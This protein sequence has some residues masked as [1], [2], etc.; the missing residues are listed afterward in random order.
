MRF[1]LLFVMSTMLGSAAKPDFTGEWRLLPGQ[2]NFVRQA[3]PR[4]NFVQIDHRDPTLVIQIYEEDARGKV[5]GT[6]FHSTDGV[7]RVNDV[8][9]NAMKSVTKW[10][11]SVLEMRTTGNFGSNE[12]MLLDRYEL[13]A[14]GRTLTVKRHFEGRSPQGEMPPQDQTLVHEL[15]TL[16]AGVAR[17]EITPSGSM[18]MYGYANRACGPS[19]GT[20][21]PLHAKVVVLESALSRIAIVTLDLGSMTSDR[22]RRDVAEKLHIPLVLLASSHTHS[23]PAFLPSLS[24]SQNNAEYLAELEKKIFEAIR[25]ASESMF[26]ARLSVGRG[27]V[28]LGYNRLVRRGHDRTR[29]VFDNLE[30]IP[31]GP[32]DPEFMLLEV[33]DAAGNPKALLVHYAVHAVVLGPKSCKFSADFPGAMQSA[34]EAAVPGIQAMF[35]QGGA[36]DINPLFQG[37]AGDATQ[38]FA[39]VDRMGN[40]LATEV[41]KARTS[42]QAMTQRSLPI[43]SSSA[44][45]TFSD[46]WEKSRTHEIGLSTVLIG[47][48]IAIAAIP[49]EPL[50]K[51]QTTWK[52]QADVAFPLFYG[53]TWSNG[54][55]WPGY[56]PDIRSAAYGGYGAD[57]TATRVEVGAGDRILQQ[58]LSHLY[59]LRGFWLATPGQP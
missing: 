22:L 42:M 41:L 2:S 53:Y 40:L 55:E 4:Q 52:Q 54:G 56:L 19:N 32:L 57:S 20:H 21:D 46:R 30:R 16:R 29:A 17:V 58:Q 15:V 31:Y 39:F 38:D 44:L 12:I 3:A 59:G 37:R 26:E 48:D 11:G 1:L 35:V 33:A 50:H 18:P 28:Q 23:A 36:G 14:N 47:R 13:D 49:G 7:D 5:S 27:S 10:N 8:L 6:G 25:R 51:L 24:S 45:M 9:G 34:I 43:R